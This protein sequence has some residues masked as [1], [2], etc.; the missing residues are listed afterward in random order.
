MC[1]ST[2][3][4]ACA[5]LLGFTTADSAVWAQSQEARRR[6]A[7]MWGALESGPYA[8][9]F[10][11]SYEL[12]RS[13]VWDPTPDSVRTG[14]LAR[15]IRISMWY[16]VP[17]QR[18]AG[19][20]SMREA[21]YFFRRAPTPYFARL[22]SLIERA[23]VIP[24]RDFVFGKSD[25][26]FQKFVSLPSAAYEGAKAA[27][28]RFPLVM[29]S[30]GYNDRSHDNSVLAEY[31]ASHG[32][33]VAT[34]PQVGTRSTRLT[35]RIN[36][37]DLETQ[38]RDLEFAMGKIQELAFVERD[39]LAVIG[40]SMGGIV[41]LQI[42]ARNPNVDAVVGLDASYRAPRF[43]P[44]VLASPYFNPR[45]VRA[46][47]LSLQSGN[48][49]EAVTQDSAVLDSLR[50]ADR[51]VAQVGRAMHG[52]FSDFAMLASLFP[53]DVQGRTA[54]DSREGF[55]AV[56]QYVRHFLDGM[57]KNDRTSM[58]YVAR[59]SDANGLAPGLVRMRSQPR[60]DVPSE[61][62]FA[63]LIQ[64]RGVGAAVQALSEARAR[65]P[66]MEIIDQPALNRIGYGLMEAGRAQIAV[67][68]FRLNTFAH[69]NSSDAFDSLAEGL[70]AAGD[71]PG[72]V[73]AYQQVIEVLARDTTLTD[74]RRTEI[75][76]ET[77]KKISAL[78]DHAR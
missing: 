72:A 37:V 54:M 25:S 40:Y 67:D 19:K 74:P 32:Y 28:G 8:V 34:V 73:S 62:D 71:I 18:V 10:R 42:A 68:V 30:A 15:P 49:A 70:V 48:S 16:P 2:T 69:P 11:V 44:L 51:Y 7:P 24:M 6:E 20:R 33:V 52:D 41:A 14:E 5:L 22:D 36:P 64:R 21:G 50:F 56:A 9:G 59:S 31:L 3:K 77:G 63:L 55:Q 46:S 13:R 43:V 29:Y 39:K 23:D 65:Y 66:G 47:I 27:T 78:Q 1:P 76:T 75:R 12:D 26:L 4:L 53:V 35:L 38:A 45:A 17:K 58:A 60:V 57:L 61:D